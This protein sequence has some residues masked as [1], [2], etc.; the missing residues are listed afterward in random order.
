MALFASVGVGVCHSNM[1]T[2]AHVNPTFKNASAVGSN[3][4]DRYCQRRQQLQHAS[5]DDDDDNHNDNNNSNLD[6]SENMVSI[7]DDSRRFALQSILWST[8]TFAAGMFPNPALAG[9]PEID[10]S[11]QLFSPKAEMLSG[12][13]TMTRGIPLN[14][15][16][17]PVKLKPGQP[18]QVVYEARFIAYLSRFLLNFD[19]AIRTWWA[20]QGMDDSWESQSF[21]R[22]DKKGKLQQEKFAEFAESVEV[23][24]SNYFVGPYG[25][26]ASV[27]AAKAGLIASQPATS[28]RPEE[29]R[30]TSKAA[31]RQLA[32]LFSLISSP[33]LQPVEE[34]KSILGEADNATITQIRISPLPVVRNEPESRTSPRRGGGYSILTPPKIVVDAPPALGDSYPRARLE[35]I[36]KP[37]SRVLRITVVDG[38]HGYTVAPD[39]KVAR[40][41]ST[42]RC[43]A[44]AIIDRFGH[45][46]SIIV[47][48]PGYGY[49]QKGK[50]P[51]PPKV[52]IEAPK[53]MLDFRPA[54]AVAEL[55][56]EIAGI[57]I[58]DGGNGYVADDF[59]SI[60]VAPPLEDPD[61]FILEDTYK[62]PDLGDVLSQSYVTAS[63]VEMRLDDGTIV[64]KSFRG[65]VLSDG[66]IARIRRDPLELLPFLV[67]PQLVDSLSGL[68][69]TIPSL[70]APTSTVSLS[71]RYRAFDPIFGPIGRVPVTKGAMELSTSEYTRLALSGAVCTEV[72]EYVLA[73]ARQVHHEDVSSLSLEDVPANATDVEVKSE[74]IGTV[75]VL[76][77]LIKLRGVK[78]LFQSSDITFLA[79]LVFGSLG[80]GATELFRRSFTTAIFADDVGGENNVEIVLLAAAALACVVTSAAAT[81]FEVLRVKSMGLV[82]PK[83]WLEVLDKFLEDNGSSRI[84]SKFNPKD[85]LPLWN[86]F[87][88]TVSRELP[89][90][91]TKFLVLTSLH[92]KLRTL[93]IPSL[94]KGRFQCSH[95]ADLILT[96]T[97]TAKGNEN[98]DW[99]DVV[100]E[101]L[102]RE[103]GIAN[104]F[105]GL[106]ARSVF[107]FLVIGLQFFLYDYVKNIFEVG[108][109]DLSLVLDVF[110][111]VR[112]GFL[113]MAP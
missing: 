18:V 92:E 8:T 77:S 14:N 52:T 76:K 55:E 2:T 68:S 39:I 30:Y 5:C 53:Q 23:G 43:E 67:R 62:I 63:V 46:E 64:D 6:D 106:P 24:L 57:D 48:D 11:G 83:G 81:P 70:P 49:G 17:R 110:Y 103:G 73:Q 34:I 99:K 58:V 61:W 10:G 89:F 16:K 42:V 3:H 79:S 65:N 105:I 21:G 54:R 13:S 96:L 50:S 111:A 104:L 86:G 97:S 98:L 107:F 56:Y 102:L 35:P 87:F 7:Q 33:T 47:L 78:S 72:N 37:T 12:G 85:L 88:P 32:L 44:C 20:N 71:P 40:A 31:K 1:Y 25:S 108:S 38:G 74:A 60:E 95:P 100:K 93:R 36:L 84:G 66:M 90:A 94:V 22:D 27:E 101:L 15:E 82:E 41:G 26:Y 80:F 75:D 4:K 91:V 109:D 69:Y 28:A 113:D 19:P 9:K 59:P 112:Q 51:T 29:A 45:I